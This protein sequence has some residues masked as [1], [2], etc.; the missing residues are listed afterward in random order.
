MLRS[1]FGGSSFLSFLR[2]LSTREKS[3]VG[4]KRCNIK[5]SLSSTRLTR[6]T[7]VKCKS[8]ETGPHVEGPSLTKSQYKV[9]LVEKTYQEHQKTSIS[10]ETVDLKRTVNNMKSIL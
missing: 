2:I 8:R 3:K 5:E 7:Y 10:L 6:R 9:M 4:P 1:V